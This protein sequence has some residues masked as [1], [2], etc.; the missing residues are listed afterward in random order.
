VGILTLLG[1]SMDQLDIVYFQEYDYAM[2]WYMVRCKLWY[3]LHWVKNEK[4]FSFISNFE[5]SKMNWRCII[6]PLWWC[7]DSLDFFIK[8]NNKEYS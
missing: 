2:V 6:I 3:W 4:G 5:C 7:I 1:S 8:D